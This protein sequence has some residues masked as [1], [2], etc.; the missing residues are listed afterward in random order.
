MSLHPSLRETGSTQH[1][2]LMPLIAPM[3]PMAPPTVQT[4][5]MAQMAPPTDQTALIALTQ[6]TSHSLTRETASILTTV[7]QE[8]EAT[9]AMPQMEAMELITSPRETDST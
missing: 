6:Q 3:V 4:A 7:T 2:I 5:L 8:T 9:E 1:P